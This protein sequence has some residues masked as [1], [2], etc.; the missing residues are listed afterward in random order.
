VAFESGPVGVAVFAGQSAVAIAILEI[1]N[2]VEHYGLHRNASKPGAYEP[3]R[4][5]HSWDSASRVSNWLLIDL[6]RHSDHHMSAAKRH[7]SLELL[8]HAPHLPAGY[9]AMF[10]LALVPPLWFREMNPR[11][12]AA[13][14]I[15]PI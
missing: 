2:D 4:P 3:V 9:G 15:A 13:R 7:Q 6:P 11:V 8:P 5:G 14:G 12:A 10:L 1:I